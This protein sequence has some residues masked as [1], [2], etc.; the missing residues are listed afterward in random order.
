[1]IYIAS[2]IV[3]Y[4]AIMIITLFIIARFMKKKE[5]DKVDAICMSLLWPIALFVSIYFLI[6]TIPFIIMEK[7]YDYFINL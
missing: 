7:L 5:V 2:Y 4:I 6:I 1:M 3:Y